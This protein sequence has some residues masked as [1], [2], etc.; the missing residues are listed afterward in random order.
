MENQ[1]RPT[2]LTEV[3]MSRYHSKIKELGLSLRTLLASPF[4]H[5]AQEFPKVINIIF[6]CGIIFLVS[7]HSMF[8]PGHSRSCRNGVCKTSVT[9]CNKGACKRRTCYRG[10]CYTKFNET[11][12]KRYPHIVAR[13]ER[14][15]NLR[16]NRRRNRK[17]R[18]A[19]AAH[20][21]E[22]LRKKLD[23]SRPSRD[24][25]TFINIIKAEDRM[26]ARLRGMTT[27]RKKYVK[28]KFA[29]SYKN[30]RVW[31]RK[32]CCIDVTKDNIGNKYSAAFYVP[33]PNAGGGCTGRKANVHFFFYHA[34][35]IVKKKMTAREAFK[36]KKGRAYSISGRMQVV[37]DSMMFQI[38]SKYNEKQSLLFMENNYPAEAGNGWGNRWKVPYP[39]RSK[40]RYIRGI[41][42]N[43][44]MSG[45]LRNAVSNTYYGKYFNNYKTMYLK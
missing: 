44:Q 30:R 1:G 17:V 39:P 43:Y 23:A 37:S 15:Q 10:K 33:D 32:V 27:A 41:L 6:L 12:R 3:L 9:T 36:Y 22:Q 34:P 28:K 42:Y 18:N 26:N 38:M 19:K 7:C 16:K 5:A 24:Q 45:Q 31:F 14:R 11:Y 4:T 20:A 40:K 2:S 8:I 25:R 35:F 21:F 13:E 29:R